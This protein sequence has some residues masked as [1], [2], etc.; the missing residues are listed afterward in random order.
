MPTVNF[1]LYLIQS[2]T[3][4][5]KDYT[6][7]TVRIVQERLIDDARREDRVRDGLCKWCFYRRANTLAGQMFTEYTCW[8]CDRAHLHH[9]TAV[10]RLCADCTK[11]TGLCNACCGDVNGKQRKAVP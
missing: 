6:K 7:E 1:D 9:N 4:R 11:E 5:A 10:P 8:R 2:A 3:Q